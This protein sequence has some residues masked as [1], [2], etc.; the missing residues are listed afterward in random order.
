MDSFALAYA[1]PDAIAAARRLMLADRAG[2]LGKSLDEFNAAHGEA[3]ELRRAGKLIAPADRDVFGRA[4]AAPDK[5]III[6]RFKTLDE[7]EEQEAAW[8]VPGWIPQGQITL[9]GSGW[10][11]R[12]N[13]FVVNIVA[14]LSAGRS[15]VLDPPG[16]TRE[17]LRVAL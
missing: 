12:Q 2:A 1:A 15:C 8:L 16:Y 6:S 4:R 13:V 10:R 5:S 11:R 9:I 7:F 3:L 14:N 17:P